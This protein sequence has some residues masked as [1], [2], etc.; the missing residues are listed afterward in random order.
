MSAP[1]VCPS[2]G[3][4]DPCRG[5]G[6]TDVEDFAEVLLGLTVSLSP[7]GCI[8]ATVVAGT[9]QDG[10][11]GNVVTSHCPKLTGQ[12]S[13]QLLSGPKSGQQ[14]VPRAV[15]PPEG[16]AGHRAPG[17]RCRAQLTGPKTGQQGV[18]RASQP[19]KGLAGHRAPGLGQW[20]GAGQAPGPVPGYGHRADA[21]GI[22]VETP[23]LVSRE[24]LPVLRHKCVRS[25]QGTPK[26]LCQRHSQVL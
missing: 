21:P 19:P 2:C 4:S 15:Q 26:R 6:R 25:G 23:M 1:I 11:H 8:S 3:L 20:P 10:A 9:A 16:P 7:L 22:V 24:G 5:N 13:G 14:G 12:M 18:P 17:A